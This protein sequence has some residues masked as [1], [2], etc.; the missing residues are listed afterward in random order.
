MHYQPLDQTRL[1]ALMGLSL[2][3]LRYRRETGFI[4]TP[5]QSICG[6][7]HYSAAQVEA[8]M[9]EWTLLNESRGG[10]PCQQSRKKKAT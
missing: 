6:K 9:K 7:L 8:V 2:Q 10:I 3:G 1:A 5:E 4:P